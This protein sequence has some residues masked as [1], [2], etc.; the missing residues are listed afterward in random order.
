MNKPSD[1][2]SI[3]LSSKILFRDLDLWRFFNLVN[4]LKDWGNDKLK[5]TIVKSL[6]SAS[7]LIGK[8]LHSIFKKLINKV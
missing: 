3:G 6:P 5:Q 8:I 2:E 7:E 4:K 1:I